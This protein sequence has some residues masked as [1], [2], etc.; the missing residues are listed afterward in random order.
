MR[1]ILYISFAA[2]IAL[3]AVSCKKDNAGKRSSPKTPVPEA[4]DLGTIVNGKNVKWASFNIGA[5][6]PYEYGDYFAWGE[7]TTKT[8]YSWGTYAYATGA[9]SKL[10]KYCHED[11]TSYWDAT[12][13]PD[14]PDGIETLYPS[15]DVAHAKL[16]G[17]WRMPTFDDFKALRALKTKAEEEN[18]DYIWEPWVF[19]TDE[20]GDE[21]KDSNG[22]VIYG[23]R[24]TRKS[25]NAVLFLPAAGYCDGTT[26]GKQVG[27]F[28]YYWSSY[29][30]VANANCGYRFDV[31]EDGS[32][33]MPSSRSMGLSVR[34]VTD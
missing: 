21:A 13:K 4:I 9:S 7:T 5:S 3:L 24:I 31:Y 16:G 30:Y 10:T 8:D 23:L 14:G 20:N 1:Q 29:L 11:G 28:G 18:S 25:T 33:F 12:S 26:I 22:N 27:I 32:G 17:G 6:K 2:A 15:D 34:P 19:A